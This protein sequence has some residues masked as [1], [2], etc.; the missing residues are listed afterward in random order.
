MDAITNDRARK[1]LGV[2][3]MLVQTAGVMALAP[4]TQSILRERVELFNDFTEANDPYGEH[5]FGKI[6]Y[7]DTDYFWKIDDYGEDFHQHEATHRLV[8]TL[9]RADEY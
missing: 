7:G 6:H 9:M 3:C 2:G 5:D 4:E 8:L 1:S